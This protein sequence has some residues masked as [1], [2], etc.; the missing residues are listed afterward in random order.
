MNSK[1][2]K[3]YLILVTVLVTVIVAA[4]V[5]LYYLTSPYQIC[6]RAREAAWISAQ[7]QARRTHYQDSVSR[8]CRNETS[9]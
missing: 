9:W 3:N 8:E 1:Q 4:I 2:L 5:G 7:P 6:W